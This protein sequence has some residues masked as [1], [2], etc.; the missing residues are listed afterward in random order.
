[1]DAPLRFSHPDADIFLPQGDLP[2]AASL[3]RVTHLCIGAHP[4][5]VETMAYDGIAACFG[6]PDRWFG[7][8]VV[9]DGAGSART[10]V[11]GDHTGAELRA[12]RRRE[13]RKAACIGEYSIQIQLSHPSEAVKSPDNP[14]L[15][16][17]LSTIL[18]A[19]TP[20]VLYLHQPADKHDT[21]IAVLAHCLKALRA[22][23]S[24]KRPRKILGCEGW[25]DLDWMCDRDKQVIDVSARP[26]LAA[27][28]V[29][30]YDS[31]I[32]GGKRYDLA[33]PGRWHGHASMLSSHTVDACT[34][35]TLAI[36]LTPLVNGTAASVLDYT[37][38]FIDRF[39]QDVAD[40]LTK[41]T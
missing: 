30:V 28:L 35:A 24:E 13:A 39:R 5:D 16:R 18:S 7:S 11:Y 20:E 1:M 25:R 21:H 23:P 40:R 22:L 17:D 29:G 36:D 3:R 31:Q 2:P 32:A 26:H 12:V 41:F 27:A 38:G 10:G 9:T 33:I 37:L 6:Q 19:V 34:A 14:A 15:Q 8:V 4:D